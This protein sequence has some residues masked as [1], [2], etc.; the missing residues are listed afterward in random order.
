MPPYRV[1]QVHT[2]SP[3]FRA[4]TEIVERAELP[5][6]A[7]GN[8]VVKNHFLGINATDIN[9]TN[10][11]YGRTPLPISCGLEGGKLCSD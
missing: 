5:T 9:I 7:P 10:G 2:Y 4:A 11:G 8:V 6:P 3:D 1:V